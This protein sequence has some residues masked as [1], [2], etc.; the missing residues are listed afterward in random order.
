MGLASAISEKHCRGVSRDPWLQAR[1]DRQAGKQKAGV[2]SD[3][4]NM[5]DSNPLKETY[6]LHLFILGSEGKMRVSKPAS[7]RERERTH[8]P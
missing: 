8:L 3:S 2:C 5:L 1:E 7:E 6:H 4:S